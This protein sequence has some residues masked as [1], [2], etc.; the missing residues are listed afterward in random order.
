MGA[1]A[2][3]V[4]QVLDAG[5]GISLQDAGRPGWRRFGV[6]V[7][8]WMDAHAA[9]WANRLLENEPSCAVIEM[10][11]QGAKL[12]MRRAAWIA[13]CGAETEASVPLWRAY[14]A[15]AGE[16]VSFGPCRFGV[17]AYLAV[18][19]GFAGERR[20]GSLSYYARGSLGLPLEKNSSLDQERSCSLNLPRGVLGRSTSWEERRDYLQP[21]CIRVWAGPQWKSFSPADREVFLTSRWT[22][23]NASDRVGYRLSGPVL[24]PSPVEIPSEPVRMG[25]IQVPENGQPI[26]TLRDGPT[27]GGYPKIALV[28]TPDLSWVAQTRPG[29]ALR[30]QLIS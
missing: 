8:G 4:L 14:R 15:A 9:G 21:P 27:V 2:K 11:F 25:S 16:I 17:W 13:V 12:E 10:L 22:V 26:I 24:K 28:D 6:P 1:A 19:G 20:F 7:S 5:L 3:A 30:F 29:Q 18:E 23:T